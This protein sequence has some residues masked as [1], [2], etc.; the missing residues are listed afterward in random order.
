MHGEKVGLGQLFRSAEAYK[1]CLNIINAFSVNRDCFTMVKHVS[2]VYFLIIDIFLFCVFFYIFFNILFF[3]L[4][5]FK[6]CFFVYEY[7]QVRLQ[8][9]ANSQERLPLA[10]ATYCV[11]VDEDSF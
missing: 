7:D 10:Y 11:D 1:Y 6:I 8:K 5:H 4:L 9:Y 3:Q 2:T